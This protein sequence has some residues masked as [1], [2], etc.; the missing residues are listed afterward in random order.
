MFKNLIVYRIGPDWAATVEHMEE[1]LAPARFV[2]CGATQQKSIGWIEPRGEKHG[3]LVESVGGQRILKLQ[4]ET[5]A[6]P[7][8]V[9]KRKAQEQIE[10][11]EATTGRKPGKREIKD[12]REDALLALLPMAFTKQS[13]VWVWIDLASRLLMTDAGSQAKADEV[14]TALVSA[15]PGLPLT[16]LQTTVSPQVAMTQWLTAASPEEWPLRVSVER[17]CELKSNDEEKSVVKFTRHNLLNDEIRHHVKQGKLPVKLALSW[18]GRVGFV[19]T[20]STQLKKISFLE[21]VFEGAGAGR[22][23][24]FDADVA[25]A[26]GELGKLIADLIEALGGELPAT[27]PASAG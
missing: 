20:E 2:E 6:V 22:E 13:S 25:I 8:S 14:I 24:G 18:D 12:I 3:A 11:I 17:E 10:H 4:I 19:L 16:L 27:P 21:G 26:T 7:G 5:K 23:D 15:M 9:V 1:A